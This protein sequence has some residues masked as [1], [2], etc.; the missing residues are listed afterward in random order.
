MCFVFGN[1]VSDPLPNW[2]FSRGP[3]SSTRSSVITPDF[4]NCG[5]GLLSKR[6][7]LS[8]TSLVG[9]SE[10]RTS[11][12][13]WLMTCCIDLLQFDFGLKSKHTICS[14]RVSSSSTPSLLSFRTANCTY[15]FSWLWLF[16]PRSCPLL[17]I[18][19]EMSSIIR[20]NQRV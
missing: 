11:L 17:H 20:E 5:S 6:V 3:H 2:I 15:H 16:P 13:F 18:Q 10:G 4:K 9:N 14:P 19:C 12:T 7:S 1:R 8:R